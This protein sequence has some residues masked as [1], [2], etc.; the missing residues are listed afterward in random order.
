MICRLANYMYRLANCM[1]R[2]ANYLCRF[3]NYLH[4]SAN[5][6]RAF[7]N[8]L[9]KTRG[10]NMRIVVVGGNA[11]KVVVWGKQ[12]DKYKTGQ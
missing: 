9:H 2:L 3:A 11:A 4:T 5:Y 6:S 8:C 12:A 10:K 7:T 1:R